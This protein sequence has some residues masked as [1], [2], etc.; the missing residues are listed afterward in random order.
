VRLMGRFVRG[1]G[2]CASSTGIVKIEKP[3]QQFESATYV[4]KCPSIRKDDIVSQTSKS[5]P[6][7]RKNI[8][9]VPP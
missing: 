7:R 9:V 1:S 4:L 3:C 5:I 2:L 8:I 6:N